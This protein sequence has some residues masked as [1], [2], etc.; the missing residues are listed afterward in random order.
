MV[1]GVGA[2]LVDVRG[3]ALQKAFAQLLGVHV[4]TY[5]RWERGEAEIGAS[6]LARLFQLGIS[7]TWVVTGKGTKLLRDEA[8]ASPELRREEL[9]MAIQLAA[10]ALGGKTLPPDKYAELVSLIY[11]GLVEG[12][13]EAQILR[14]ARIAAL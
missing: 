10:E 12:L 8:P 1:S 5:A 7:P 9:T 14:F 4:N 3:R 6:A 2:R 13:P 11:E